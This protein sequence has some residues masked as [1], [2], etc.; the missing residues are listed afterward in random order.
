MQT[1]KNRII[2]TSRRDFKVNKLLFVITNLVL[3]MNFI[4][5]MSIRK[6][7]THY[8]E[9]E[10]NYYEGYAIAYVCIAA[11]ALCAVF[12]VFTL[13][14][15]LFSKPHADL[16]YSLPSSSK[17]RF[18][19]KLL[20]LLKIHILPILCWNIIQFI[21]VLLTT[22]IAL[23]IVARYSA[24]LMLTQ[25]AT[26]LFVI[27][28]VLLSMIC[29]GRLAE[30]IY[31][32]VIIAA[33]EAALPG[34]IY[35]STISPFTV[36]Y[37][38]DFENFTLYWPAWSVLPAKLMDLG[39]STKLL[40]LLIGSVL[41]SAIIITLLYFLYK[42]RDGRATGKPFV[43]TAFREIVLIL[44]IVTVTTYV[45]SDPDNIVLLPVVLLSYLLI[46][47]FSAK[48]TLTIAKF[49]KW[50]AVFAV[51]MIMIFAFNFISYLCDGFAG[52]P[53]LS[54][55]TDYDD[56]WV[57]VQTDEDIMTYTSSYKNPEG[58]KTLTKEQAEQLTDIYIKALD[59][60]E[61]SFSDYIDCLKNRNL[62]G[63]F[64]S[65]T[66]YTRN[67]DDIYS[68]NNSIIDVIDIDVR[69]TKNSTEQ[70]AEEIKAL[71]FIS[72]EQIS[73]LETKEYYD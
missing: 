32:A 31:T 29:C 7:I 23:K 43:F 34:C 44:G 60:R 33:C 10:T 20:T 54:V 4:M 16:V 72:P 65:I 69:L 37:P 66:L 2:E 41:I 9:S 40:L 36:Q 49:V 64:A 14:R 8:I 52:K 71:D 5:Q 51:Y 27:L 39:Y 63:N 67:S 62:A 25:L 18:F 57:W 55:L 6:F 1:A 46:R 68:D 56:V 21:D 22:D 30:M 47:I 48:S 59:S 53:D 11:I 38:Y 42:K 50:I 3:F 13:F 45:L 70:V 73:Y 35:Y 12:T 15:E 26:S 17:E 28:A 61:K 24:V 19:S 58:R